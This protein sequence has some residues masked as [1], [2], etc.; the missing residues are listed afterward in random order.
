MLNNEEEMDFI[1]KR[2]EEMERK[3]I[4]WVIIIA[5]LVLSAYVVPYTV[6]SDVDYW[7]G[8]FL[9]WTLFAIVSI[10]INILMIRKW[11]D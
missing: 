2:D 11:R 8:S 10:T 5:V 4:Y 7:Y 6:L 1:K 9:F 3:G